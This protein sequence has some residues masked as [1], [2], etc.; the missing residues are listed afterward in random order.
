MRTILI[1]L[2][3]AAMAGGLWWGSMRDGSATHLLV[4]DAVAKPLNDQDAAIFLNIQN[5]GEPDRLIGAFSSAGLASL[6][7]PIETPGLPIPAGPAALALDGAHIRLSNIESPMADGTL[8]PVELTFAKA[9]KIT[10][11]AR[12]SDPAKEGAASEVGLFGLGEI[13]AVGEGEPAPEIS[14]SVAP[15]GEGWR[16]QVNA[17]DFRFS[18]ELAGLYHVPGMGHGHI[19]VG[20]VKLGRLYEPQ[21]HIGALPQGLHEVRVTLNT[22]DHRAYV[23]DGT[24]VTA[25]ISI[26]V[27]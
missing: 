18:K 9:G 27:D 7:S 15:E 16:L 2:V 11:K 13:C 1:F 3:L 22:N 8:L 24:P 25:A 14:L 17:E 12:L 19:Y 6:Y 21:A 20:G 23:V 10:I 5:T 4:S 26:K